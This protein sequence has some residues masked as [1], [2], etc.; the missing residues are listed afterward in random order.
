MSQESGDLSQMAKDGTT[1][2]GDAGKQNLLPSVPNPDQLRDT[3]GGLGATELH[4]AADNPIGTG[5]DSD[6]NAISAT[7]HSV[8]PSTATKYSG[9]GG[10]ERRPER[11]NHY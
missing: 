6:D 3:N 10:K 1:V 5:K 4:S 7:G 8:P 2:P 11:F 9:R